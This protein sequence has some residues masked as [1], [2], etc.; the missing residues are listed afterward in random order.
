M[1]SFA[2]VTTEEIETVHKGNASCTRPLLRL[3][4][5]WINLSPFVLANTVLVQV[6]QT[7]IVVCASKQINVAICKNGFMASPW[8][9]HLPLRVDFN[10][11]V[12]FHLFEVLL[13]VLHGSLALLFQVRHDPCVECHAR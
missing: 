7:L 4:P 8:C 12:H 10:P 2:L 1:A 13:R 3:V 11:L 9:K 5:N 6:I